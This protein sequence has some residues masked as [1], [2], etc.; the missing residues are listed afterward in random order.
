M[1]L[2]ID[3]AHPQDGWYIGDKPIYCIKQH[4]NIKDRKDGM[5]IIKNKLSP[6]VKVVLDNMNN[7]CKKFFGVQY[8]RLYIIY[9]N[10]IYYQGGNGPFGYDLDEM[11]LE[12]QK[13]LLWM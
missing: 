10:K 12:L 6:N 9:K 4:K 1:I 11:E 2:Y 13:L 7:D 5:S 3:E 8:E